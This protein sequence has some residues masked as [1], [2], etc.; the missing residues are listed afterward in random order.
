MAEAFYPINAPRRA[1]SPRKILLGPAVLAIAALALAGPQFALAQ[2][3]ACCNGTTATCTNNVLQTQC[4]GSEDSFY[5]NTICNDIPEPCVC[6]SCGPCAQKTGAPPRAAQIRLISAI[7][8]GTNTTFTYRVCQNST[9]QDV[10]HWVLGLSAE[11]CQRFVS[12]TGGTEA[13]NGCS[14]DPTTG[15]FGVKWETQNA[16]PNCPANGCAE[17]GALFTVTISG[18]VATGCVRSVKK[19]NGPPAEAY[20]CVLG[21][22]CVD[23][24]CAGVTC[25]GPTGPC[26]GGQ[27]CDPDTGDCV[28]LPDVDAGIPCDADGNLCTIDECDGSGSCV[29]DTTTT[30]PEPTNECDGGKACNPNTGLCENLPD[31][32][33]GTEC[34]ADGNLCTNDQCDGS[35]S[36]VKTSMVSCPGPTNSCDGGQVCDSNT[37][38]C[39]DLVDAPSGT[40]CDL[41]A[42]ACTKDKC[43]GAGNCVFIKNVNCP[44]S[45]GP[46]DAGTMCNPATGGCDALSDPPAGTSCDA[47]GDACTI[48][49]CDGDGNCDFVSD[50]TCPGPTNSCDGGQTCVGGACV[51]LP[52]VAS[53]ILCELDG[54]LCTVDRCDGMGQCVQQGTVNC[55]HLDTQ[56]SNAACNSMTGSCDV[57]HEPFSTSCQADANFCTIDH[58]DGSGNCVTFDSVD[59]SHLDTQCSNAACNPASGACSVTHEPFSTECQADGDLCTIDHCDGNGN[60]VT[61]DGVDCSGPTGPCD[62]G[63]TCN[64]ATGSCEDNAD[65]GAGDPCE[66]D[67]DLCTL[68]QCDGSGNCV[69]HDVVL[70]P[71]PIGQCDGGQ[72]CDSDTGTCVD[73]PDP[74]FGDP[75]DADGNPCTLDRC[76]GNGDCVNFDDVDCSHLDSQCS[77]GVCNQ[78]TGTCEVSH[79]PLST[80]CEADGNLCTLDH[81]DGTGI[82][83]TFDGLTCPGPAGPCDGG[84]S[85][86]PMTGVCEDD[87]DAPFGDPCETDGDLCTLEQCDG[88]GSCV[89][90]DNVSCPG[91]KGPCDGGKSCEPATGFCVDDPDTAFGTSCERD[92]NLCT[93]DHCDGMGQCVTFDNVSCPGAVPPCDAGAQCDPDTGECVKLEHPPVDTPCE[94]DGD[95]CTLERCDGM[96]SCVPHGVVTCP[97]PTGECDGGE[98]CDSDTGNCV[99]VPDP[100]FGTTCEADGNLCTLDR[101]DGNG[102]C[103]IYDSVDCS[104]LDTGCSVGVCNPTSGACET[105]HLPLSTDCEADGDLC[106]IDHCDGSGNCVTFDSVDCSHLDTLCSVGVCNPSTGACESSHFPLSTDCE[107]DGNLC[108]IDHC[109]GSGNC[110]TFDGVD[111]PGPIGPCDGGQSCDPG[112]GACI[113]DPD[114]IAGDPC[115]SD[116]DLC[117]LEQCD[118][119]GNCVP[120]DVITC[121]DPAGPCDGGQVC[122]PSTGMCV[123][124]PDPELST[125]CEADGNLCTIDHCDGNGNCVTFDA[126]DCSHLDVLCS[127]GVCNPDTGF[128][129]QSHDP[130]GTEC[131]IDGNLCTLEECDGM[132][133]CVSHD[134]VSCPGPT[135]ECDGGQSCDPMT[136]TCEDNPDVP[137]GE[138][139]EGDGNLCTAEIC[140]G[141]GQCVPLLSYA[142]CPGPTGPCDGGQVCDPETGDCVDA[143]DAPAGASCDTDDDLCT[144]EVCDGLGECDFQ[145]NVS[146]PGP[147][148][149]CESGSECNPETGKCMAL[150]DSP[151]GTPCDAD[152]DLCTMDICDGKGN[153][154]FDENVECPGPVPPCESGAV[155]DSDTGTCIDLADAPF[156]TPCDN[157]GNACTEDVCD[158][159][160][161]CVLDDVV[162]GACCDGTT[163]ECIDEQFPENCV[164]DQADFFLGRDCQDVLDTGE[165]VRHGGACCDRTPGMGGQCIDDVLPEDCLGPQRVWHKLM[166]CGEITCQEAR[167]ACCDGLTGICTPNVLLVACNCSQ[168]DWHKGAS[169]AQISCAPAIGACCDRGTADPTQ[170]FCY[171][172]TQDLCVCEMCVW[173][174]NANCDQVF[175][176]SNFR[177]IPTTSEWGLV[178]MTLLLLT[179]GKVYFGRREEQIA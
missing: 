14:T 94:N 70:C 7:Y 109:D 113:D 54:D 177:V 28:D 19:I 35:G 146:C 92:G 18:Q 112:T 25:P 93:H 158:G 57:T 12:A 79:L 130:A 157:D 140:N 11:C 86:N 166:T 114:P 164:G 2:S 95:M 30:C 71:G 133:S 13:I 121:S 39:V 27:T 96:G 87:P 144:I 159:M 171:E 151:I 110:V 65:P 154:V 16:V 8:N 138:E 135:N 15:I 104:H 126:V 169:C 137:Y 147:V 20:G 132:G 85:C 142:T 123:N 3:G 44:G 46:C 129:E 131:E 152:E 153:C 102:N 29:N 47:D 179:L 165:C 134:E 124:N 82:C 64:P 161:D 83:V 178:V 136:G 150:P 84:Q 1:F 58:C 160:G 61:F 106:T 17:A 163:G 122:E 173:T 98:V 99:D 63:Q 49:E 23:D 74:A 21:P 156:G 50:V 176:D 101:C 76:D 120:H 97:G 105:E 6:S 9:S 31:V 53:G 33:A 5:Q 67:G 141:K 108:T 168:C 4:S 26:D 80:D 170:A 37:G 119:S 100:A 52:D 125:H 155:C 68:E 72:S 55:S 56:C 116:G 32:P 103:V 139:C 107:A 89:P 88:M 81:C 48:D 149:P 117:T 45:T 111:C 90:F 42:N 66:S 73:N 118:G 40:V 143:P 175:C 43:D 36:C 34:E 75:C 51:D 174:K 24:L 91:P 115:E 22:T 59:C 167:G 41:D 69:P 60:C 10:S 128:C 162:C 172:S 62:G 127:S 77:V 78:S 145:G 148:P 38:D